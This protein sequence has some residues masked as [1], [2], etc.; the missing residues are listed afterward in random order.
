MKFHFFFFSEE[1]RKAKEEQ[2][3]L[4]EAEL[5][6]TFSEFFRFLRERDFAKHFFSFSA[7]ERER[8]RQLQRE[9]QKAKEAMDFDKLDYEG[10]DYEKSPAAQGKKIS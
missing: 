3:R 5:G 2:Q 6:K 9:T 10:D 8:I 1:E 4:L 7:K